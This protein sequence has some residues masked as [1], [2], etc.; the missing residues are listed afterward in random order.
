M[1]VKRKV[2]TMQSSYVNFASAKH[3]AI[4]IAIG[5]GIAHRVSVFIFFDRYIKSRYPIAIIDP[6]Q[7]FRLGEKGALLRSQA[8]FKGNN[9]SDRFAPHLEQALS[10]HDNFSLH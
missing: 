9:L 10:Y 1:E 3:V 2:R 8:C 4:G 5:I 6:I 7:R